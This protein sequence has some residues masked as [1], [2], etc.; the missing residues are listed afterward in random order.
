MKFIILLVAL[1]TVAFAAEVDE[2]NACVCENAATAV[3]QCGDSALNCTDTSLP[4]GSGK[5]CCPI[6]EL[7][8]QGRLSSSTPDDADNEQRLAEV[9]DREAHNGDVTG[10][11]LVTL[12]TTDRHR[13]CVRCLRRR[14]CWCRCGRCFCFRY[15]VRC[16]LVTC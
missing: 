14:L 16:W 4:G 13:V 12:K 15:Y 7:S 5:T 11:D 9:A 10:R 8:S 2:S 1:L 3:Q 6:T